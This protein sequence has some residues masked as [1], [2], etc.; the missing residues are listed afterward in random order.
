MKI[1][2]YGAGAI[3]GILG[4]RL[5]LAGADLALVARGAHLAA[6]QARGLTLTAGARSRTVAVRATD[7]PATLGVQDI[8]IVTLKAHA[9]GAALPGITRLLG[10]TTAVVTAMNGLPWWYCYKL[11]GPWQDRHLKSVDPE[12]RIWEALG[13]ERAVGCVVYPAGSVVAPG[14]VVHHFGERFVLGEPDGT[15]SER[16]LRLAA[17]LREAGFEA[18]VSERIRDAI[19]VK[20]WGNLCFNP[21]SALTGATLEQIARDP[22]VRPIVERAMAEAQATGEAL[23]VH[24]GMTIAER[25]ALAESVGAFKSSMLQD[26][27]RGRSLEV[28][29]LVAA[30]QEVARLVGVPTPTIDVILALVRLRARTV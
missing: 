17:A 26:L 21:L 1:C 6:I 22:G 29:A 10:A 20:L 14:H 25:I 2:I 28:D 7:D 11:P 30:V 4:A 23:G 19:W 16:C 9:L 27:E 24:F 8:V 12:G 5:A 3:G 18:P 13:P 15:L